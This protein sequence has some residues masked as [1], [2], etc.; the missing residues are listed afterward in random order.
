MWN[1]VNAKDKRGVM[2]YNDVFSFN[3]LRKASHKCQLGVRWKP[4]TQKYAYN[5]LKNLTS[6]YNDLKNKKYKS[7]GFYCF[8]INERGKQRHI[9][10]LHIKDRVVQKCFCDNC[11][12]PI[13]TK[14]LIYDTGACLKNKGISFARK[15][16]KTHLRKYTIKNKNIGYVLVFDLKSYFDSIPHN[17]LKEKVGKYIKDDDLNSLYSQLVDDCG[18]DKGLGLGSQI[19]QISAN[20]YLNDL[21]QYIK[22]KLK[23]KFY[24]RYMDDGYLIHS[25]KAYLHKCLKEIINVCKTLKININ[26]NKTK[27]IKLSK[28]FVFLK[29]RYKISNSGRIIIT[30]AKSGITRERKKLKK[31]FKHNF[32]N[33]DIHCSLISWKSTLIGTKAFHTIQNM[34]YL[35]Q[36]LKK[37][38]LK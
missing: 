23:I 32:K 2:N 29:R 34:T 18:G 12:V 15:R 9:K 35:Y 13:L 36:K 14:P 27:I 8:D 22:H 37:E 33:V 17:L 24:A 16:I 3:N 19:S 4:S 10:S 38:I 20:F 11:L 1:V 5:E 6:L 26:I 7:K 28:G 25:S 31:L 21:D 30:P